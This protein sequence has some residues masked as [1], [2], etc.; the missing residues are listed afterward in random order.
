MVLVYRLHFTFIDCKAIWRLFREA[1]E[2]DLI[3]SSLTS[4]ILSQCFNTCL[5]LLNVKSGLKIRISC[6][7]FQR[8]PFHHQNTE[9]LVWDVCALFTTHKDDIQ[10]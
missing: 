3:M 5:T 7:I 8:R 1:G 4:V 10:N 9:C 2:L 6:C